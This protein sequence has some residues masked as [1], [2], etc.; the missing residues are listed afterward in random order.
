M[1][2]NLIEEIR[3]AGIEFSLDG[4]DRFIRCHGQTLADIYRIRKNQF[5]RIPDL[6]LWP[7]CHDEVLKIVQLVSK[8]EAV[9]IPYGGGTS[10]S[11]SVT[12]PQEET[13]SIAVVDTTQMNKLLWLNRE[14]LTACFESGIVGQDLEKILQAEG[15]TMGHEPDSIELSTL[16]GWVATRSSG[17]KKNFYGN[18]ED[19]LVQVKMATCKG[20]L[21][22][23]F[24]APRVS[25]GPDFDQ[26]ILG[27]EGMF[28]II[29]EVVVKVSPMPE[30]KKFGSIVFPN[31]EI[32]LKFLR[33]VARKKCQPTSI[34]LMDK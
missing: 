12:C 13:R 28:G 8:Y 6:V 3:K 24:L 32:G 10:V 25:C 34:R 19:L 2:E 4:L 16:G 29:T 11:C 27:S 26:L 1:N 23:K 21:E 15:L 30:V 9:L 20:V 31:F 33:E 18:I 7:K 17:M 14:N 22:R 5:K